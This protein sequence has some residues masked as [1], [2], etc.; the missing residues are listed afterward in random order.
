M[1]SRKTQKKSTSSSRSH[2]QGHH[3]V[4]NVKKLGTDK[5]NYCKRDQKCDPAVYDTYEIYGYGMPSG[6]PPKYRVKIT[7]GK[8]EIHHLE[9][10]VKKTYKPHSEGKYHS[11]W[12]GSDPGNSHGKTWRGNTILIGLG[13]N[14]YIFIGCYIAKFTTKK[15]VISLFRSPVE[16]CGSA[17]PYAVDDEYTY[18]FNRLQMFKN[19]N[20]DYKPGAKYSPYDLT[21]PHHNKAA[22]K[23][24]RKTMEVE[25]M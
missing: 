23:I 15:G 16:C 9:N 5:T 8:Y 1:S 4:V 11:V 18:L 7:A 6:C 24:P 14:D 3:S 13:G 10:N 19:K 2:S 22:V 12:L 21:C 25:F 20:L 17:F